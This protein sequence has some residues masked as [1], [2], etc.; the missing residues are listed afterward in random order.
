MSRAWFISVFLSTSIIVDQMTK[1]TMAQLNI[2]DPNNLPFKWSF[3]EFNLYT[4]GG[5]YWHSL[6]HLVHTVLYTLISLIMFYVL[7]RIIFYKSHFSYVGSTMVLSG[8]L[9]NLFDLLSNESTLKFVK[10]A[11]TNVASSLADVC[12]MC[13]LVILFFKMI[14]DKGKRI[15]TSPL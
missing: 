1:G 10:I 8:A 5:L 14:S 11:S 2:T 3:L 13:G 15:E 9:S 7:I 4:E 12:I 6:G